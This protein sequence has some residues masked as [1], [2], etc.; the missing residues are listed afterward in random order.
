M[1]FEL[2]L[3]LIFFFF[4]SLTILKIRRVV[5]LQNV[6]LYST[7]KCCSIQRSVLLFPLLGI[8]EEI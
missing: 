4:M 5:I 2:I 8:P 6:V 3:V 7:V 1:T